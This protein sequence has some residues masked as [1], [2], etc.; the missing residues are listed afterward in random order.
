M[1]TYKIGKIFAVGQEHTATS[2][3]NHPEVISLQVNQNAE[4]PTIPA[5]NAQT[6]ANVFSRLNCA[7]VPTDFRAK[8]SRNQLFKIR[9]HVW[10]YRIMVRAMAYGSFLLRYPDWR[11]GQV[12]E[13]P[14][15]EWFLN[16][17]NRQFAGRKFTTD[18]PLLLVQNGHT[19]LYMPN[20]PMESQVSFFQ[21]WDCPP[22]VEEVE[23]IAL[24]A[25]DVLSEA[26]GKLGLKLAD[27]DLRFGF[28][29]NNNVRLVGFID[30]DH[31]RLIDE[32]GKCLR[33]DPKA[34]EKV[35]EMSKQLLC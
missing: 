5:L 32:H 24:R 8:M 28:D 20:E 23:T 21:I 16:A 35:A 15:V 7:G 2:I 29:S 25:F 33:G 18:H 26:W 4:F 1:V 27:L 14:F 9:C 34:Y 3:A 13:Q 11:E 30:N 10:P 6:A 31:C 17:P 22:R 12:F 19:Q